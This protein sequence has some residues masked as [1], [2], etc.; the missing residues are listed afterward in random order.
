MKS[1]LYFWYFLPIS[2][3]FTVLLNLTV[4]NPGCF[5]VVLTRGRVSVGYNKL[6]AIYS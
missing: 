4:G 3:P 1:D 5:G 2:F 6:I